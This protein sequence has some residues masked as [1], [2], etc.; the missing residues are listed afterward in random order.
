MNHTAIVSKWQTVYAPA[1][2]FLRSKGIPYIISEIGSIL[3]DALPW[4]SMFG[5]T[6]WSVDLQLYVMAQGVARINFTQRPRAEHALWVPIAGVPESPGP[7]VRAPYYALPFVADFVGNSSI[8]TMVQ[9]MDLK[10]DVFTA[11][12]A[13]VSGHLA[14]VAVI[15]L[16]EWSSSMSIPRSNQTFVLTIPGNITSIRVARLH[17]DNGAQARGYDANRQNITYA[18]MQWSAALDQG[19]G[20]LSGQPFDTVAVVKGYTTITL[21]DSEAVLVYLR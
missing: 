20:H 18:G 17:A 10:S 16:R 15:N 14:R 13:Y 1:N 6:L 21:P 9:E 4:S 5:A 11:Y 12:G 7:Q 3:K 19:R 8:P 2:K